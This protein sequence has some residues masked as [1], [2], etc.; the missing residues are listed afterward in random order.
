MM[1]APSH[2]LRYPT[3]EAIQRLAAR[4]SLPID[5]Y[6]QDW[7]YEVAD[8]DRID[9]FLAAYESGDLSEDEK[10]TLMQTILESFEEMAHGGG[11]LSSDARL[12]RT[13]AI[14]EE[15]LPLHAYSIWYWSCPEAET[16]EEMFYVS[17]FIRKILAAHQRYFAERRACT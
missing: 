7:E 2:I 8:P 10:F 15:N 3:R 6:S 4:F 17:P 14:I 13:L 12:Q 5:P 9:E 16:P 11:D 1:S